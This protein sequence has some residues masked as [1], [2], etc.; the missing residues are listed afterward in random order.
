MIKEREQ[1]INNIIGVAD[2]LISVLSFTIAYFIRDWFFE[3]PI[4]ATNEYLVV[5]VLVIP[6]WFILIKSV[7]MAEMHRTKT[8]SMILASYLR[9]V[10]IGLGVIFLFIFLFKLVNISRLMILFSGP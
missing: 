6:T 9:V 3:P 10:I 2:V 1:Q 5:G 4:I 8:Y 7:H